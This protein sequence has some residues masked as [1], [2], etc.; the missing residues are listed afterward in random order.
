MPRV[1]VRTLRRY[2]CRSDESRGT[3]Q[4]ASGTDHRPPPQL[5]PMSPA[6]KSRHSPQAA[7]ASDRQP[8]RVQAPLLPRCRRPAIPVR[9]PAFHS[10]RTTTRRS[11]DDTPGR[12]AHVAVGR[13]T[14]RGS[15]KLAIN[16]LNARLARTDASYSPRCPRPNRAA[17]RFPPPSSLVGRQSQQLYAAGVF[18]HDRI[19]RSVDASDTTRMCRRSGD[20]RARASSPRCPDDSLFVVDGKTTLTRGHS[21]RGTTGDRRRR[22]T[23]RPINSSDTRRTCRTQSGGTSHTSRQ[24]EI[25]RLRSRSFLLNKL[26][27]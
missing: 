1:I 7:A 14:D 9:A 16:G 10:R 15:A 23:A 26:L 5:P 19:G 13:D 8:R 17:P 3:K 25:S 20:S 24:T 4:I 2:S 21:A 27:P 6:A 11:W 22:T 12:H 18:F